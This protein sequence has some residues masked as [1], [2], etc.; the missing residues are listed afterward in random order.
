MPARGLVHGVRSSAGYGLLVYQTA[1]Q[2]AAVEAAH[3]HTAG[4]PFAGSPWITA[5]V[6]S[7]QV[8]LLGESEG[9]LILK[10]RNG[11]AQ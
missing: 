1:L 9:Q 11:A 3:N 4:A 5:S 10:H 8:W 7:G 2:D 6:R